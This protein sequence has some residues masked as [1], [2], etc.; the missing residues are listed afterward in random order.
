MRYA[1]ALLCSVCL[2]AASFNFAGAESLTLEQA[3]NIALKDN[4]ALKAGS[5][6]VVTQEEE[7]GSAKGHLYPKISMEEKYSR[8][9]SPTY[10]FMSKLDQ[11]RF[12][13]D[14]F[15]TS[16]LNDPADISDY[17]TSLSFEQPLFV[18]RIYLGIGMSAGELDAK[19]AEYER[20]KDQVTL[21]V[22]RNFLSV[23][24]AEEYLRIA[25]AAVKD[26]QEHEHLASVR[27][28]AG[29]GLYSDVLRTEVSVKRSEAMVISAE[30]NLEI[31][32][33]ALGLVLGRTGPVEVAGDKPVLP[34]DDLNV[35]LET[36]GQRGDLKAFRL[37]HE[38]SLK[39]VKLER[40][41]FVPEVGIGGSY[42]MH[43]HKDPFSPE[44]ESYYLM[45]FLRWNL[46]DASSYH[47]IRKAKAMAN[48]AEEHLSGLEKEIDFRV[49]EAYTKVREKEKLLN[50]A[51]AVLKEAEEALR[52]V[53]VRYENALA[54]MI[55]LLDTQVV[56]NTA[57]AELLEADN[58]YTMAV[59][60][61][62][63]QSGVLSKT[64]ERGRH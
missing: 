12:T 32:K 53:R 1:V 31:A 56:L 14:D 50:L 36:S 41:V 19:R 30:G 16:S 64:L 63:F 8:T 47:K 10:G 52:L 15:Q 57:R 29:A 9:N 25:L 43:D 3:V 62:Y 51:A 7:L 59:A 22:I 34:L 27:Y 60:D 44:G 45:G 2:M 37:R 46:F 4:P 33:R 11:E 20:K 13:Q 24:T 38:N 23:R 54:P 49:N 58:D 6:G 17:Q 5:W 35:Y 48:E 18:P 40:S 21:D 55:D 61:L 28:K 42:N 26:A 39:A